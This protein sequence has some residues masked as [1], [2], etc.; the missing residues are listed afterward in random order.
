MK[1]EPYQQS[2]L[3]L[4]EKRFG[5]GNWI[6]SEL[7]EYFSQ[8][9]ES[10]PPSGWLDYMLK[11]GLSNH[12]YGIIEEILSEMEPIQKDGRNCN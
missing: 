11:K 3:R 9:G 12:E 6:S 10:S 8:N 5:P 7:S 2:L 4:I 1:A